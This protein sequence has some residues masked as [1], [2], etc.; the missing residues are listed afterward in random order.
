MLLLIQHNESIG[1]DEAECLIST[2]AQIALY[3]SMYCD[4]LIDGFTKE[5][6][7]K[8]QGHAN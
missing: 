5:A 2:K 6:N 7:V 1:G 3:S 8:L 4:L